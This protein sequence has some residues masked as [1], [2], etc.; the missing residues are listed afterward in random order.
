METKKALGNAA[1]DIQ[2]ED[3]DHYVASLI[4]SEAAAANKRYDTFGV[5]AF[6]GRREK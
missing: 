2:D 3:I 6:L 5:S 4:A 1:T